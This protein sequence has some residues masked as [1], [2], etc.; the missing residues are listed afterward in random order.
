MRE[1]F[2]GLVPRSSAEDSSYSVLTALMASVGS[3]GLAVAA[4]EPGLLALV[5]QHAAAIRESLTSLTAPRPTEI[6]DELPTE[7]TDELPVDPPRL[8]AAVLAGYAEGV[9][10]AAI[11]HGWQ[12]PV[13][14]VDWSEADWVLIRLLAV[15]AVARNTGLL[16]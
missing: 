4:A 13:G 9:R 3:T 8:S 11:E 12:P 5:D 14:P 16:R 7:V 2:G 1:L 10:D 15:C 6:T